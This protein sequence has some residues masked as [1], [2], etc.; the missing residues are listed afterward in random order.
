MNKLV[1]AGMVV[2]SLTGCGVA[3]VPVSPQ[4]A[5]ASDIAVK[6]NLLQHKELKTLVPY[7]IKN[8]SKAKAN[9]TNVARL[10]VA[11]DYAHDLALDEGNKKAEQIASEALE[12]HHKR[13][14]EV[15]GNLP[16]KVAEEMKADLLE[17]FHDIEA[18]LE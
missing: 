4:A 7:V 1:L 13:S 10:W 3:S 2:L 15:T 6:Q 9:K 18:T 16:T 17:A 8:Q 11:L 5:I 12:R 14:A